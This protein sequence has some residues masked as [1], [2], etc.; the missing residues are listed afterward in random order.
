M[1]LVSETK[2]SNN[3]SLI[4]LM[5]IFSLNSSS[6]SLNDIYMTEIELNFGV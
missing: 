5:A 6:L 1:L 3:D 2:I 4:H